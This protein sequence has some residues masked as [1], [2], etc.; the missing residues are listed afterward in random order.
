MHT[1]K[2]NVPSE[3]GGLAGCL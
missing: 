1:Y 3:S 2:H